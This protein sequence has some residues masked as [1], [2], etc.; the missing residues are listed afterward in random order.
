MS[1]ELQVSLGYVLRFQLHGPFRFTL[2]P[3]NVSSLTDPAAQI[4]RSGFF[5]RN[6]LLQSWVEDPRK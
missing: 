5:K 4:S 6:S 1:E 3:T 2:A